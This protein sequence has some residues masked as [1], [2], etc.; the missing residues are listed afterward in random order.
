MPYFRKLYNIYETYDTRAPQKMCIP[1]IGTG[2]LLNLCS[3]CAIF[4]ICRWKTMGYV[5]LIMEKNSHSLKPHLL[6][7]SMPLND[8]APAKLLLVESFFLGAPIENR[9]NWKSSLIFHV[10]LVVEGSMRFKK[11]QNPPSEEFQPS[12]PK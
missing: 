8:K 2:L 9:N 12:L 7:I 4:I 5:Y 11:H 1:L 10:F 3:Q 6:H